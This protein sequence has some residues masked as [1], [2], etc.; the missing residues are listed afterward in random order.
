M[1]VVEIP[2]DG[3]KPLWPVIAPM[4]AP[5]IELS[6]GRLTLKTVLDWLLDGRYLLWVAH[7]E[8]RLPLAAFITREARYPGKS[9]LTIDLCGGNNLEGWL[10]EADRVFRAHSRQSGLSGVELYGRPGWVRALRRLGWRQ[11]ATLVETD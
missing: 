7:T 9:M 2:R 4:L 8:D 10:D 3:I 6:M 11:S 5:A 1:K